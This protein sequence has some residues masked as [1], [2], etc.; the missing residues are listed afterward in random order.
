MT[1]AVADNVD[2]RLLVA[3]SFVESKWGGSSGSQSTDNAFGL[4][5]NGHLINFTSNGG[6][7][8]GVALAASTLATH[9]SNGQ[10]SVSS[11]YSGQPGA[12]CVG[13][14]CDGPIVASKLTALGGNP[15]SLASP[16]YESNGQFYEKQ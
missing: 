3:I 16:C 15:N 11:L 10:T 9:I 2:P 6:W 14:H 1:D 7:G 13:G 5:S 8:A 12:Y 4:M